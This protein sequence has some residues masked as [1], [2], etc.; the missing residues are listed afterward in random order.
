MELLYGRFFESG[1]HVRKMGM[2]NLPA[3]I[4]TL[5]D[6]GHVPPH[7][8][9]WTVVQLRSVVDD[10]ERQHREIAAVLDL[11]VD[12]LVLL[13]LDLAVEGREVFLEGVLAIDALGRR[14]VEI[15]LIRRHDVKK[16]LRI[17]PAPSV[18]RS[19]FETDDRVWSKV[20]RP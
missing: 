1:L 13:D 18:E 2:D 16:P 9:L 5:I 19:A 10:I 4:E 11:W 20:V 12:Q 6:L 8:H 3:S 17:A 14:R 15:R 7:G